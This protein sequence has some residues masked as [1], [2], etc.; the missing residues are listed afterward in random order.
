MLLVVYV[1]NYAQKEQQWSC[2]FKIM[3]QGENDQFIYSFLSKG[4][5]Q[6]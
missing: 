5:Q 4:M 3:T 1:V 6:Y 2:V